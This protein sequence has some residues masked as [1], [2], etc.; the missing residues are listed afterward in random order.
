[1]PEAVLRQLVTHRIDFNTMHALF[2]TFRDRK[3]RREPD[4]GARSSRLESSFND[5]CDWMDPISPRSSASVL[6]VL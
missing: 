6:P 3:G 2:D 5:T 1:M 4:A